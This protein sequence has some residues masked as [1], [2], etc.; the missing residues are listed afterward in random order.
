MRDKRCSKYGSGLQIKVHRSTA[1]TFAIR[2][3]FKRCEILSFSSHHLT[4]TIAAASNTVLKPL[5]L[6]IT[7]R[8]WTE[9]NFLLVTNTEKLK[10]YSALLTLT[11]SLLFFSL[12][13]SNHQCSASSLPTLL[14]A[15]V[16]HIVFEI[17]PVINY[18]S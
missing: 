8:R 14:S 11:L 7:L 9:D 13:F 18:H 1:L 5:I 3:E 10:D 16:F 4:K 12:M 2:L 17:Q 15:D 6:L